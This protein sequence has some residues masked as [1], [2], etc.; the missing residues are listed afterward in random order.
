MDKKKY[1]VS[2]TDDEG[3]IHTFATDDP[4]RAQAMLATMSEDLEN[5]TL[6]AR[7]MAPAA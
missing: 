6:A 4:D 7:A 2:G 3:D 1:E 5:V